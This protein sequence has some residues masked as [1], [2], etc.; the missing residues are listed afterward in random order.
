M[1]A[2]S[3]TAQIPAT[4]KAWVVVRRGKPER[5]LELKKD[6]PVSTKLENGEVLVRVQA[7]AL[8]PMYVPHRPNSSIVTSVSTVE[9]NS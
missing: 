5:A 9:T 7:A 4:Q 8:N 2:T 6:A 3:D 1:S